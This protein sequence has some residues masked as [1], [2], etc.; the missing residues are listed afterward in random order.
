M[1]TRWFGLA[2][3]LI[4]LYGGGLYYEQTF[5]GAGCCA[6]T[7]PSPDPVQAER[8]VTRI[9]PRAANAAAQREA[10][11]AVNHARPGE[12]TGWLRLAYADW[13]AH[14]GHMTDAGRHALDTSYL[15][16]P[17]GGSF[18]PWRLS[19]AFNNWSTLPVS[20]QL[21]VIR[22]VGLVKHDRYLAQTRLA[23]GGIIDP[24]GRVLATVLGVGPSL[25]GIP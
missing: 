8:I 1:Q 22:E 25:P 10:A 14:G 21:D 3:A 17:Y 16:T 6:L 13:L 20:T 11:L 23:D 19:L 4:A 2:A 18:T 9:D 12:P 15:L 5:A 24:A 7:W